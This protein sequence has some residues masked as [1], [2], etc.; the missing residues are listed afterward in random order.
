MSD[1]FTVDYGVAQGSVMYIALTNDLV[2][3]LKHSQGIIFADDTTIMAWGRNLK[4]LKTKL[5]RDLESLQEW[6]DAN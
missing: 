6:F 4:Y 3:S 1:E 2:K 5:N